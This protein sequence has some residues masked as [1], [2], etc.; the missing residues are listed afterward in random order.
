MPQGMFKSCTAAAAIHYVG[1]WDTV[2]PPSSYPHPWLWKPYGGNSAWRRRRGQSFQAERL[3]YTPLQCL[4][5]ATCNHMHSL[6]LHL[7]CHQNTNPVSHI[8]AQHMYSYSTDDGNKHSQNE[9]KVINFTNWVKHGSVHCLSAWFLFCPSCSSHS[10]HTLN[11]SLTPAVMQ[12]GKP[13]GIVRPPFLL[14]ELG[15]GVT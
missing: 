11:Y 14:C 13:C 8:H 7:M 5:I 2:S 6:S 10:A 4:N 3:A 1:G 15:C 12:C 9:K